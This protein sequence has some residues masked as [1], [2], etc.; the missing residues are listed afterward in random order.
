MSENLNLE[1]DGK[2]L[3]VYVA[4]PTEGAK[5]AVI[6]IEEIWGLTAHIKDI[7][8]RVGAQGYLAVSPNLLA[9]TN[10]E[11]MVDD[12]LAQSLFDPERRA[13]VQPQLRAIMAPIQA[14]DFSAGATRKLQACYDYLVQK[15]GDNIAVMGFCFGGT[16]SFQLAATEPKL[17]AAIPFYGHAPTEV[18]ELR[19][20]KCPILAFY[21]ENDENLMSQL[22]ELEQNMRTAE[23]NFRPVVYPGCGHAFFNNT[24]E[25]T[26][27]AAAAADAWQQTLAFLKSNLNS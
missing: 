6:V 11:E 10:I 9:E 27:N 14:P 1:V 15:V 4:G 2:A 13:A 16:Y 19:R 12:E 17:K 26:Y 22:P 3:P 20:I 24:N 21:G 18:E 23:V 5:G 7:T 25:F 8:D